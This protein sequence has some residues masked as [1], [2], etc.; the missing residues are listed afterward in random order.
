MKPND[1][2]CFVSYKE[3]PIV[4]LNDVE[5]ILFDDR[6]TSK[7]FITFHF[8]E[9]IATWEFKKRKEALNIFEI[10]KRKFALELEDETVD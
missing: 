10:L 4:D 9:R 6:L 2:N 3:F 1:L 5:E 7:Y 8:A